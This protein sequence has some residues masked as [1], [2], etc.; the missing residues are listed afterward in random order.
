MAAENVAGTRRR[1]SLV[2]CCC[3]AAAEVSEWI[4]RPGWDV[5][6]GLLLV[7]SLVFVRNRFVLL[8]AV[9][10]QE[11]SVWGEMFSV[12]FFKLFCVSKSDTP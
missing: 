5:A 8:M 7:E 12:F 3:Q 2:R 10:L 11:V 4:V 6:L 1:V 9:E